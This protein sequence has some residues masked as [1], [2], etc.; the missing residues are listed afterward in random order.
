[1]MSE[2]RQLAHALAAFVLA[3][4]AACGGSGSSGAD[5]GGDAG[6]SPT[7]VPPV[8]VEAPAPLT[9]KLVELSSSEAGV[10]TASWLPA[11]EDAATMAAAV[12]ELHANPQLNDFVPS[13]QTLKFRGSSLSA[14]I[15]GLT[16]G[17][18]HGFKLVAEANGRRVVGDLTSVRVSDTAPDS[19][20]APVTTLSANQ[21][22]SVD[23]AGT[24]VTL[25][26]G[27]AVPA[28]GSYLA[29]DRNE[30]FL[31]RVMSAQKIADGLI[32]VA[33]QRASL[34]EVLPRMSLSSVVAIPGVPQPAQLNQLGVVVKQAAQ[35]SSVNW[36][37]TG[38]TLSSVAPKQ[39]QMPLLNVS[40]RQLGVI[41]SSQLA[42]S[43]EVTAIKGDWGY[44]SA[45]KSVAVAAGIEGKPN[46]Q[47]LLGV[48]NMQI[49]ACRFDIIGDSSHKD[50]AGTI[51]GVDNPLIYLNPKNVAPGKYTIVFIAYLGN[52]QDGC[53]N[54]DWVEAPQLSIDIVVTSGSEQFS[55]AESA[56]SFA[57]N[58]NIENTLAF[59]FDPT[60]KLDLNLPGNAS[61]GLDAIVNISQT[62]HVTASG[63]GKLNPQSRTL[64]GPRNFTK[65]FLV[66]GVPVVLNGTFRLDF[67]ISGTASGVINATEQISMGYSKLSYTLTYEENNPQKWTI[68]SQ[69]E[70]TFKLSLQGEGDAEANLEIAL[71]PQLQVEVYGLSMM[72]VALRPTL[73][74][75]A[76]L[77]ATAM[78]IQDPKGVT[79]DADM[80][81]TKAELQG[82]LDAYGY[83]DLRAWS[84]VFKTFP[85]GAVADK[86]E[87]YKS[88][89]IIDQTTI[90]RLPEM[91]EPEILWGDTH[92]KDSRA[93]HIRA[94]VQDFASPFSS[95]FGPPSFLPFAAW[96][97]P[98]VI[99]GNDVGYRWIDPP[100]GGSGESNTNGQH[101]KDY[102]LVIDKP[103]VYRA[104]FAANS[105][106]GNWAR[107][108][109][110]DVTLD[111]S[112]A[113]KDG[114]P[115]RWASKYSSNNLAIWQAG[116]DPATWKGPNQAPMAS[117]TATVNG[118]TVN[119]DASASRDS[120][121]SI[122][123][124]EWAFGDGGRASGKTVSRTYAKGGT[125]SVRLVVTDDK[126]ASSGSGQAMVVGVAGSPTVS[127]LSPGMLAADGENQTLTINGAGFVA[128]S[129][130]MF[131]WGVGN[132][133]G[134]WTESNA[135][136][137]VD[138]ANQIRIP[139][140]P[141]KVTDTIYV[142]ICNGASCSRDVASVRVMVMPVMTSLT[143]GS[144]VANGVRQDL[145]ISGSGFTSG[146][147]GVQ[148]RYGT[149]SAAGA[150]GDPRDATVS[151]VSPTQ[152][153]VA[154]N[155]G[156]AADNIDVRVCNASLCTDS[157]SRLAMTQLLPMLS[158]LSPDSM[159]A[160]NT[161]Q[162]LTISGN[163]FAKGLSGV[164]FRYGS[165][166][167]AG[168]WGDP[169]DATVVSISSNQ[170]QVSMNPGLVADKID[171]RV[172]NFNL[173]T[174]GSDSLRVSAV[175]PAVNSVSP[176]SMNANGV[177]QNL[178]ISG[179]GFVSGISYVQFKWGVGSGAN[180]WNTSGSA[181]VVDS[182]TLMHVSINPGSVSDII[183]VRVCNATNS[184]SSGSTYVQVTH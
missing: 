65:I 3:A 113:N 82:G 118:L 111:M 52:K 123:S 142:Q 88:M 121:G 12:Y 184:C 62:L 162:T 180:S 157:V 134:I 140:N 76:G 98:K 177:R 169:R 128:G 85:E 144:M 95:L 32:Q 55:Q 17:I 35:G 61:V 170:I 26:A 77:H 148:F 107:Q 122:A 181:A 5:T 138:S 50:L 152:I 10:A 66:S 24:S 112:D 101:T 92:P 58:V 160:N 100:D 16:A 45:P 71:V 73:S 9:A 74:A 43:K 110:P 182:P 171:V 29:S 168:N 46:F 25:E 129:K 165:G 22:R 156:F 44:M 72:G 36:P 143:P 94:K 87:T 159:V 27:V 135:A 115:D 84:H 114:V 18:A 59:Q 132:G 79:S 69:R 28:P 56:F 145:L 2:N 14:K 139:M 97:A 161:R 15:T 172:C 104:R 102:W 166:S 103:G 70:P 38:F 93:I 81:L 136:P 124:Y 64:I 86:Y 21:I 7:P 20:I 119:F 127:A 155:P 116:G 78:A 42:L 158:S 57:G 47:V 90:L 37:Q 31:L 105:V 23:A 33:T 153:R 174:S 51:G 130:V 30:G 149:G 39:P 83:A 173:C 154:M 40:A 125:Y 48:T 146:I 13:S 19:V 151:I 141:G 1:M 164:Q 108:V 109:A 133:A 176:G 80:W 4:L 34:S 49:S 175:P 60:L 117:F 178:D 137:T 75:S 147:T 8:L 67:E 96:K 163:G 126:G 150:W 89:S 179:A 41:D 183:Y 120:D 68:S 167:G 106:M 131:R 11:S 63:E 6:N 99:A 91:T 54:T 53:A